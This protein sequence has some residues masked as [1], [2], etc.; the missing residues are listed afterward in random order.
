MN[1][2]TEAVRDWNEHKRRLV[3]RAVA[4][5]WVEASIAFHEIAYLLFYRWYFSDSKHR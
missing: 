1:N 5:G 4:E 3:A 2:T